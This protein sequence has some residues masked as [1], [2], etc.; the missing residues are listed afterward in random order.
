[1]P[2]DFKKRFMKDI[3]TRKGN[4]LMITS[5]KRENFQ[6]ILISG[7]K[8]DSPRKKS[9]KLGIKSPKTCPICGS[10]EITGKS[11]IH[12]LYD[13]PLKFMRVY[14]CSEHLKLEIKEK[15]TKGFWIKIFS[16]FL[17]W[18]I[19]LFLADITKEFLFSLLF[20]I[21][22]GIFL[23]FLIQ[24]GIQDK[25]KKE[26]IMKFIFFESF[27]EGSIISVKNSKWVNEFENIN[28]YY[29][30]LKE[31]DKDLICLDNLIFYY[32]RKFVILII[33][34][35]ILWIGSFPLIAILSIQ[36]EMFSAIL[37]SIYLMLLMFIFIIAFY[38]K[39][40]LINIRFKKMKSELYVH[41]YRNNIALLYWE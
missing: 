33:V 39:I 14:L 29:E 8:P 11:K 36:I 27:R 22:W 12:N 20:F 10:S 15:N 38:I 41:K 19:F 2:F 1:M 37:V 5:K 40:S 7:S 4:K 13:H 30:I 26:K 28:L 31:A 6:R 21:I 24:P 3:F 18:I 34:S 9:I 17:A 32:R 35:V 16:T 25:I 23:A